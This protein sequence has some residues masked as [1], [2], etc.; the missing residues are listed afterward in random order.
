MPINSQKVI[1]IIHEELNSVEQRGKDYRKAL[2][3][4]IAEIINIVRQHRVRRIMVQK[5]INDKINAVGRYLYENR[6]RL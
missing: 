1:Q 6:T 2:E 5:E 4:A 3:E